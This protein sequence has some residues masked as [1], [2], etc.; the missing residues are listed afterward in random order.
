[1]TS[2]YTTKNGKNTLHLKVVLTQLWEVNLKLNLRKCS[3]G[4]QQIVFLGHVVIRQGSYPN[5][6]KVQ[7]IKDFSIPRSITNVRA[8]LG[9][10]RYY[11]NFVNGYAKIVM[12]LFDQKGSK[13]PLDPCLSRTF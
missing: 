11:R 1:M 8:F 4:A 12:P 7:A 5:P 6:K 13:F 3:F 10:T 9:L 2:T